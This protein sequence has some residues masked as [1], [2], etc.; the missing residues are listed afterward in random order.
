LEHPFSRVSAWCRLFSDCYE[1][2]RGL[3]VALDPKTL[4]VV[5]IQVFE[6]VD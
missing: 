3:A 1:E 6:R 4:V 5:L 2:A